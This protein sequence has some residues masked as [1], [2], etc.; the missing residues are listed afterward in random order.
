MKTGKIV[1]FLLAAALVASLS[2]CALLFPEPPPSESPS[3]SDGGS[4]SVSSSASPSGA[5]SAS[6]EAS[7]VQSG[8]VLVTPDIPVGELYRTDELKAEDGTVLVNYDVAVPVISGGSAQAIITINEYYQQE[9]DSFISYS[10]TELL[11]IAQ[12]NFDNSKEYGRAFI[13]CN[14]SGNYDIEFNRDD[15][16]S[17]SRELNFYFGTINV[18]ENVKSDTFDVLTGAR[19]TLDNVF[20]V[21]EDDYA[22]KLAAEVAA[23]IGAQGGTDA[24]YYADYA[25][26]SREFFLK[27]NFYL[28]EY[29]LVVYYP[30]VTIGPVMLGVCRFEIPYQNLEEILSDRFK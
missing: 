18:D 26:M 25:A 16:I 15:I 9:L 29:G 6:P 24:G 5:P 27:E 7:P 22:D 12:Q 21:G 1:V 23:Q 13:P 3:P 14:A 2:G 28:T 11:E 30:A 10:T 4:P 17:I 8:D 19:I 20:V